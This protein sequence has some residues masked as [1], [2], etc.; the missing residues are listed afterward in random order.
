MQAFESMLAGVGRT[1]LVRL[2]GLGKGLGAAVYAKLES[3]NPGGSIKDRIARNMILDAEQ[4]GLLT[5]GA[6]IVEPTS[7]NTGIGLAFVCALRG[8]SLVLTMPE[9]MSKERRDL[10]RGFGARLVLTP[11][12]KGMTGA[13]AEA[14]AILAATP[15]AF[16]PQQFRNP[17]NPAAHEATTGPEIWD[18]TAGAVDLFV[19]G[20]GTGGTITGVGR[21]LRARKSSVRLVAV[22]PAESPVLSGGQAGPHGIQGIGAGFV[23]EVLDVSLLDEILPVRTEDALTTARR[24]LRQEGLLCGISAGANVFAALQL[25]ARPE[26]AGQCIVTIICDTGE[27]YLSSP[28]FNDPA[29]VEEPRA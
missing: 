25:A 26:H 16:M 21:A 9:S 3:R 4:R 29:L 18:A 11:A 19:A 20:V 1:P 8:Y 23:P 15:G 17:A 6:T 22:E 13:I 10:L 27:R 14:E 28:L 2:G 24:L 12:A 5:P 7:G